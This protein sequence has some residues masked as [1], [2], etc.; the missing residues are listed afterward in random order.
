M[1]EKVTKFINESKQE[2]EEMETFIRENEIKGITTR[3]GKMTFVGTSD[4]EI[5]KSSDEPNEPSRLQHDKPETPREVVFGK[6]PPKIRE[7]V[8][9]TAMEKQKLP[10]PFPNRMRKENEEA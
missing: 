5:N 10:V 3:G 8:T 9:K 6:E 7:P 1:E 2:H 4:N